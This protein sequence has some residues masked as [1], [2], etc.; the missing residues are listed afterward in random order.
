MIGGGGNQ[1]TV[2]KSEP[3]SG[4]QPFLRD[5]W[6]QS[7][8]AFRRGELGAVGDESPWTV[9]GREM[10]ANQAMGGGFGVVP[11]AQGLATDT[12][13]GQ[14]LNLSENP[15]FQ[16]AISYAQQPVID[17]WNQ[18]VRPGIDATFAGTAG[19]MGSGA[20]ANA[21]NQGQDVLARNLAG[22]ATQAGAQ[23]YDDERTRQMQ[24]MSVAPGL[25][26]A[27]YGAAD[28][29]I[30]YGGQETARNQF[31]ADAN[32]RALQQ[33]ANLIQGGPSF[34]VTTTTESGGGNPFATGLGSLF[35]LGGLAGG[36]GWQPFA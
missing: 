23:A 8:G 4:Q 9:A 34:G 21:L 30:G 24:A 13:S 3:W 14:Y 7:Q 25:E 26:Q 36:L 5:I 17:A 12:L 15:Y 1:E 6:R 11:G 32:A 2:Q 18:Q 28:R 27:G 19:G 16:D 22:A 20:F 10:G 31:E 35:G 29:L 33:Y